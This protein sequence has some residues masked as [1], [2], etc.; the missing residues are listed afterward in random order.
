MR[1]Y[2]WP[3]NH[4]SWPVELTH[5]HGVRSGDLIFTG[6]Q[7]DLDQSGN[8]VNTG[9][10]EAQCSNVIGFVKDI[11]TDLNASASEIVRWVVYFVGDAKDEALI[12]SMLDQATPEHCM[13]TVSTVCLPALCY[14][15]MR[16]ELEAVAW[17]PLED[18]GKSVQYARGGQLPQLL[19]G[20]SHALRCDDLVFTSDCCAISADGK[21][22]SPDDLIAQ[23]RLMMECL[24]NTLSLVNASINDVLKLNVF[25]LGDGTADN[26]SAPAGIRASYFNDPGPAATGIAVG[27]FAHPGLMTKIAVTAGVG[28]T[29]EYSWPKDHWDWTEKLPYKHGNRFGNLIHLGGQVALNKNAEVLHPDDMIEQTRIAMQNIERVLAEFNATLDDVVKVTTF[30]QGSASAQAL[31][32]NLLIRSGSYNKP[33]PA[34]SGIPVTTLVYESMVIEIEVIAMLD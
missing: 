8:V 17:S 25:Y 26:W 11:L 23:T 18:T 3:E 16:I 22:L 10:L 2:S 29:R 13:P 7:A 14:P 1:S 21:V 24:A 19:A 32:E 4:W 20:F 31:H 34:T 30:Y 9:S 27:S 6:G 15:G 5:Q 12:V 28:A 33:G